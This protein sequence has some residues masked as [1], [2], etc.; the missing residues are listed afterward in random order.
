[1]GDKLDKTKDYLTK[2][3]ISRLKFIIF[4]IGV[5]VFIFMDTSLFKDLSDIAKVSI[6]FILWG[7][8]V[9][10]KIELMP[11][12]EIGLQIKDIFLDRQLDWYEKGQQF[13]NIGMKLLHKAGEM[14]QIGDGEQF[15]EK[16]AFSPDNV[17]KMSG[18]NIIEKKT[19][20]KIE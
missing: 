14:W 10:L 6:Y 5:G 2:E 4:L 11:A 13:G 7:T 18:Q 20:E 12:K 9:F 1:M 17:E 19:I 3:E 8:F 15:P 16:D